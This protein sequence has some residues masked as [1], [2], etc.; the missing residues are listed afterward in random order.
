LGSI[1]TWGI[2]PDSDKNAFEST[3]ERGEGA[4]ADAAGMAPGDISPLESRLQT[5]GD[6]SWNIGT[7]WAPRRSRGPG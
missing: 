4:E 7:F 5:E 6:I 1:A 3:G 2:A